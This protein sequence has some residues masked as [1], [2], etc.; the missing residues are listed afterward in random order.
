MKP[1]LHAAPKDPSVLPDTQVEP[2]STLE[3]RTRRT[4]K[5][6]YKLRI[7]QAAD[8][9][10]YGELG[11]LLRREKLYSN[12]RSQWRREYADNGVAG[13]SKSS[14]GPIPKI[15]AEWREIDK[16]KRQVA[17]L[18]KELGIAN[19][20]LDIQKK[21]LSILDRSSNGSTL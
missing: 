19:G 13:L 6:E 5:P 1:V 20:C 10:K 8:A 11:A 12:R 17:T 14:P 15:S 3:K 18:N 16:L 2:E 21:F 4:F 7:L 9:C